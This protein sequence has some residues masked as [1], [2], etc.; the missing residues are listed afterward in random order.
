MKKERGKHTERDEEGRKKEKR[1][2][3][4]QKK[5]SRKKDRKKER[6]KEHYLH[7]HSGKTSPVSVCFSDQLSAQNIIGMLAQQ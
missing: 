3:D 7:N 4:E 5:K 2:T 1:R 6:K